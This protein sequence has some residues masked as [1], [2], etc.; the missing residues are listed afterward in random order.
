LRLKSFQ[1]EEKYVYLTY[2][3]KNDR[4]EESRALLENYRSLLQGSDFH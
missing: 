4:K 1:P 2:S 3:I